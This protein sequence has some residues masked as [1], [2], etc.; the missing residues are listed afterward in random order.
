M[1]KLFII[2]AFAVISAVGCEND[3]S[4][5]NNDPVLSQFQIANADKYINF[6]NRAEEYNVSFMA[7]DDWSVSIKDGKN[8]DWCSVSPTSGK[9][10]SATIKI[11]VTA[12]DVLPDDRSAEILFYSKVARMAIDVTQAGGY[13]RDLLIAIYNALDG[14]NWTN[15]DNWCSDKP[16]NEWYGVSA[17]KPNGLVMGINLYA[18]NLKGTIPP[19]ISNFANLWDLGIWGNPDLIGEIPRELEN[20]PKLEY[21][22]LDNN[23]LTGEIPSE[24][25]SMPSLRGLILENNRLTGKIPQSIQQAEWWS[26]YWVRIISGNNFD[27]SSAT[28][29]APAL[30]M[31]T[32]DGNLVDST[33]Y[34]ENKYTVLFFWAYWCP[35]SDMFAPKLVELYKKYRDRG[36]EVFGWTE[37]GT[38][39]SGNV[40]TYREVSNF[41][42]RHG[43]MWQNVYCDYS[44]K[45]YTP[46]I[47][48]LYTPAVNIVDSNGVIVFNCVTDNPEDIEDFLR[49]HLGE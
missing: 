29:P 16:L 17:F 46:P 9:A 47:E 7:P 25:G 36:L 40:D 35:F 28:I 18:N 2:L 43:I 20:M 6:S 14:D 31:R 3:E 37:K 48:I 32:M 23:G 30:S 33:I 13:E 5:T 15:N 21:L 12:N 10:G 42:D 4:G 1:R 11:T 49:E 45:Q 24:L 34:A 41:I 19:E 39:A 8:V 38:M 26:K 22:N 27:L 44:D